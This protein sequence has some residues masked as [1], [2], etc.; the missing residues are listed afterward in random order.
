MTKVPRA[1]R[2]VG[3]LLAASVAGVAGLALVG[4]GFAVPMYRH[5]AHGTAPTTASSF[6][7]FWGLFAAFGSAAS[8]VAYFQSH[9][10][11]GRGPRGGQ[12]VANLGSSAAVPRNDAASAAE[13]ER[14]A[15]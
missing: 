6:L 13:D 9:R 5:I 2:D 14:R 1:G 15:A 4:Y 7:G 11:T 3:I 8:I 10:P 12:R